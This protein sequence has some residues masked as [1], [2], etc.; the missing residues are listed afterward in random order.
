MYRYPFDAEYLRRLREGDPVTVEHF[1]TYFTEKLTIKLWKRGFSRAA[2]D[3]IVQETFKRV[4]EKLRSPNGIQSPESF[5]AFVFGVCNNYV[6][7]QYREMARQDQLDD[8]AF[9]LPSADPGIEQMLLL[10]E[11]AAKVRRTLTL[12]KPKEREILVAI[13]M[14]Q[15]GKDEVCARHGVTRTYLRVVLHRAIARFRYFYTNGKG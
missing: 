14:E 4:L 7:E 10:G 11:R 5:G 8:D 3:D 15:Q 9:D 2:M 13:F 6:F 1:V 12:M